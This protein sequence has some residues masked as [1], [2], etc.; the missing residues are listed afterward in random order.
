M[1]SE[2]AAITCSDRLDNNRENDLLTVSVDVGALRYDTRESN[3]YINI[4]K[5]T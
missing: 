5:T 1:S 2:A 4:A 3:L